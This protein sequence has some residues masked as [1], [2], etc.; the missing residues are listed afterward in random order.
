MVFLIPVLFT[1]ENMEYDFYV[2]HQQ[3]NYM[4]TLDYYRHQGHI[5]SLLLYI[6]LGVS[7]YFRYSTTA[8]ILHRRTYKFLDLIEIKTPFHAEKYKTFKLHSQ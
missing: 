6:N 7:I 3:D 4:F 2:R 1:F 8:N 5:V